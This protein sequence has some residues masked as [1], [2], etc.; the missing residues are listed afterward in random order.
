MGEPSGWG[1]VLATWRPHAVLDALLVLMTLGYLI[2]VFRLRWRG[3]RWPRCRSAAWFVLVAVAL[4][5][6]DGPVG[7]YSDVLFWVHMVQHLML[8]MVVPVAL[9]CAAPLR[10]LA[11]VSRPV[12]RL[13]G[14]RQFRLLT[15]PVIGIGQY[16]AVVVLTHLT[17]FQQVS[18]VRP[19]V[20][21]LE[22]VGYVASGWLLFLPLAGGE[23]GP[24]RLP[25][26]LRIALL[27]LSMGVDTMTGVVLMLTPFALAPA[28]G[29]SR[30]GWG[31]AVLADQETAGAVMWFGGDVLMVLVI[32]AVGMAWGTTSRAQDGFGDWLDGVRRRALLGVDDESGAAADVDA[33][34]DALRRYNAALAELHRRD[35]R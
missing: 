26:L 3:A 15:H 31:P 30:P 20:R 4:V 16:A 25:S 24:W 9:L 17:G 18:M 8:I 13:A 12:E 28:Y 19:E 35:G 32:I 10:L 27:A 21:A 22:L 14:S 29:A 5:A 23:L 2:G 11:T 7:G 33:D 34:D 1:Q 6:V